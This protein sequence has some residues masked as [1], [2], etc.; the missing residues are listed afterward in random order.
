MTF[1]LGACIA[2]LGFVLG[3]VFTVGA[4]KV[5]MTKQLKDQLRL[6]SKQSELIEKQKDLIKESLGTNEIQARLINYY[7]DLSSALADGDI[8]AAKMAVRHL[9]AAS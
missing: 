3:A 9:E 8:E 5:T 6:I 7:R 4:D 2:F 1:V